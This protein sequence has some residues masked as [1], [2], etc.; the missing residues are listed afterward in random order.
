MTQE[1][2]FHDLIFLSQ[3]IDMDGS[4]VTELGSIQSVLD[5]NNITAMAALEAVRAN[6]IFK[7]GYSLSLVS[8]SRA[9]NTCLPR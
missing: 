8:H 1:Q 3:L 7:N 6:I 5:M 2:I 9:L 4:N